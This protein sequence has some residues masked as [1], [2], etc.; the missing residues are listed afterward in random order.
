[1]STPKRKTLTGRGTV[2]KTAVVGAKDR[3]TKRVAAQVVE[4]TDGATLQ[5]FV[6][7]NAEW[8]AQIY[9]DDACAYRALA[10]H[11][12]VKHSA[13]QYVDGQIH[14][15]GVESFWW[16]L[17]RAHKGSFHKMSKKHLQRYVNE[18]AGR[19]N[20]REMDTVT[21]MAFIARRLMGKRLPYADLIA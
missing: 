18:F 17:K 2:G 10:N 12:S 15:N 9:T 8:D 7:D 20:I 5:R 4:S 19:H 6:V 1:M 14:T 11:Q 13:G 21:Q 16:M 3:K